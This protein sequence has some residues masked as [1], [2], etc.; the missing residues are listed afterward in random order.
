MGLGLKPGAGPGLGPGLG[1]GPGPALRLGLG[2][3]LKPGPGPGPRLGLGPGPGLGR[4]LSGCE[5]A[6]SSME[7]PPSEQ[8]MMTGPMDARSSMIARYISRTRFIF[9]ASRIVLTG[10]PWGGGGDGGG[11]G[12]GGGGGEGDGGE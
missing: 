1:P 5:A 11:G 10:L 9:L 3:G 12:G 7:V 2:L 4:T 8:A 6:R